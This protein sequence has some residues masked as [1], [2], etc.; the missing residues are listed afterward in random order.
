MWYNIF[1]LHF[2]E[3]FFGILLIAFGIA[4]ILKAIFKFNIPLW[5]LFCGITLIYL[6]MHIVLENT[7]FNICKKEKTYNDD[8]KF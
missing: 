7:R 4:T 5:P 6:G 3:L 2:D 1:C 8:K